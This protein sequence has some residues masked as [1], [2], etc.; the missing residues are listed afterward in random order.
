[1]SEKSI[2]ASDSLARKSQSV[3]EFLLEFFPLMYYAS[4]GK[5]IPPLP[6]DKQARN[7]GQFRFAVRGQGAPKR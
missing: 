1:M 7:A 2:P 6:A 3:A 4:Q 5:T